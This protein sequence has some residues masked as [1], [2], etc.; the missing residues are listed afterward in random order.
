MARSKPTSPM[1]ETVEGSEHPKNKAETCTDWEKCI[2]SE[3]IFNRTYRTADQ[4][5]A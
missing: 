3:E 1:S 5:Q 4:K 2:A